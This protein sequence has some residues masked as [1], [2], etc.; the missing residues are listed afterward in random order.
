MRAALRQSYVITGAERYFYLVSAPGQPG[1]PSPASGVLAR[2]LRINWATAEVLKAFEA[3][4]VQ[5]LLLKGA[6]FARWLYTN[7]NPR[8]YGD[9]DLLVRP[10]DFDRAREALT[11][12]DFKPT[13][14]EREMPDWWREHAVAWVRDTDAVA[15]DLHRTLAGAGADDATVWGVL[16][17]DSEPFEIA[18]FTGRALSIP[19]RALHVALHAAQHGTGWQSVTNEVEL[20]IARESLE[21]WRAAAELAGALEATPAFAAGLRQVAPGQALADQ[22]GLPVDDRVDLVL[23]AST[24]P[25]VAMGFD[26]LARARGVLPRLTILRHKLFPPPTFMRKWSPVAR[27]GKL[28]L[29][30]AYAQRQIWLVK[31]APAG[32]R[33]WRA[34]RSRQPRDP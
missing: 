30:R 7:E 31:K 21:T 16:S 24:P 23:R 11:K 32:F 27:K 4:E 8:D 17:A 26:Q 22:L 34:A 20:V 2:S 6:S 10:G 3:V 25:P 1:H 28:G 29:A 15:L 9:C 33:A 19:A 13:Y 12:L 14:E 5:S 18:G